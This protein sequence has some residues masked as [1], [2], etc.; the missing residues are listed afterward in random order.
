MSNLGFRKVV[1]Y[2]CEYEKKWISEELDELNII[3]NVCKNDPFHLIKEG[4]LFISNKM[5]NAKQLKSE[6]TFEEVDFSGTIN[7]SNVNQKLKEL[8]RRVRLIEE[9]LERDNKLRFV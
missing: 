3:P 1:S 7:N 2:Y 8:S 4:S 6:K 9:I 5:C